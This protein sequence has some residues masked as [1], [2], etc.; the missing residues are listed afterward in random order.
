MAQRTVFDLRKEVDEKLFRLPL[1]FFDE[2][3]TGDV[4]SRV[5]N[6]VDNISST[7]QQS[8]TQLITSTVTLIGILIMMLSINFWLT[9]LTFVTLPLSLIL[10]KQVAGRVIEKGR[11]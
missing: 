3:S 10:T 8:L 4:L 1:R 5:T 2:H 7:L 11:H 9:L 6:D